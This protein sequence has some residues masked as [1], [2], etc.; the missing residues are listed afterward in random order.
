MKRLHPKKIDDAKYYEHI[1][2]VESNVRPFYDAVRQRALARDMKDG[3][4][5]LD[6]GCGVF[7]TAQYLAESKDKKGRFVCFDQSYTAKILIDVMPLGIEFILGDCSKRLPF[8]DKEFD[9]VVAGEVIE[10]MEDPEAF[11]KELC[12]VG[13][14]VAI[15]TVDTECENAKKHGDYPEHLWEFTKE[16]LLKFFPNG[17]YETVGDYHFIYS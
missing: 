2:G 8:G 13:K 12:R 4:S 11:A 14:K 15:S 17:K 16:D 7:G 3:D 10:H 9:L 6:V 1:W 5:L